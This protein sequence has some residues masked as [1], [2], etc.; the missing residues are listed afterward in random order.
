[1]NSAKVAASFPSKT[2][3][4]RVHT[5]FPHF[6]LRVHSQHE[7]IPPRLI[8]DTFPKVLNFSLDPANPDGATS[9]DVALL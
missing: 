8:D 5:P 6:Y 9:Q 2:Y 7:L 1:M 3:R 4:F